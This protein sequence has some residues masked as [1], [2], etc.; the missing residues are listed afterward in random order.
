MAVTAGGDD[1]RPVTQPGVSLYDRIRPPEDRRTVR[2]LP[3]LVGR[4][5]QLV[6]HA[7]GRVFWASVAVNLL[8]GVVVAAQVLA[9]RLVLDRVID[10]FCA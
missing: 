9:A 4:A 8:A 5:V 2:H 10:G 3:G 7:A 1:N 6:R